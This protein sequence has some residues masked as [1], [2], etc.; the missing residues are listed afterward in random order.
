M[1][2]NFEDYPG[3]MGN[4]QK[5][6]ALVNGAS[7]YLSEN[8]GSEYGIWFC[9]NDNQWLI[10][11]NSEKG[12]CKGYAYINSSSDC[13]MCNNRFGWRFLQDGKWIL[14][15][16]GDFQIECNYE[17]K[18][19]KRILFHCEIYDYMSF[20]DFRDRILVTGGTRDV[21][22]EVH[23]I[24]RPNNLC[25]SKESLERYGAVGGILEDQIIICGGKSSKIERHQSCTV[26]GE[27]VELNM[28]SKRYAASSVVLDGTFLW[29]TGSKDTL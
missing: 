6:S 7:H 4:Y 24:K 1:N 5:T 21:A 13:F 17:C 27:K 26:I 14:A 18:F 16:T 22:T 23:D 25:G 12:L 3:L 8:Q 19:V 28:N 2:L 20:A 15:N 29:I 9:D 11:R 10:G